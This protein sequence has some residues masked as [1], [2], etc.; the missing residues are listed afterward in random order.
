MEIDEIKEIIAIIDN[1]N[2]EKFK[3]EKNDFKLILEKRTELFEE[4]INSSKTLVKEKN[5]ISNTKESTRIVDIENLQKEK[6]LHII[7]APL[8]GTYYEASSPSTSSYVKIGD[9]VE[10]GQVICIIEAMKMINEIKSTVKGK[11][12]EILVNNEDLVEYDTPLFK[13]EVEDV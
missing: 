9:I 6:K 7:G 11:I 12:V 13:I 2:I 3:Y 8:I 1:S 10:I 4:K 5:E